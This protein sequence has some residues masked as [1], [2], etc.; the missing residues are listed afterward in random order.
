MPA[1]WDNAGANRNLRLKSWPCLKLHAFSLCSDFLWVA[2]VWSWY[3]P[4]N[5]NIDKMNYYPQL[6]W[7][8]SPGTLCFFF[9]FGQ[10][11]QWYVSFSPFYVP[12]MGYCFNSPRNIIKTRLIPVSSII[13]SLWKHDLGGLSFVWSD[14]VCLLCVTIEKQVKLVDQNL[15][16]VI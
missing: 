8:V 4:R 6:D 13:C 7:T 14:N 16:P 11:W 12:T 5:V 15:L 9:I 2:G 1:G 3:R 10:I